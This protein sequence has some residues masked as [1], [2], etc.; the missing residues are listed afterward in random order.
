[1]KR[2]ILIA[3]S[4]LLI[5]MQTWAFHESK[6]E[7]SGFFDF[8]YAV[9]DDS[10]ELNGFKRGQFELD[11]AG[12]LSPQVS[13]E[14]A[15]ALGESN[16]ELGAGLLDIHPQEN[17]GVQIGQFDVPVGRDFNYYPSPERDLVSTPLL[18]EKTYDSWND[19]G[20]QGYMSMGDL[21]IVLY[22]VNGA[23]PTNNKQAYGGKIRTKIANAD[24]GISYALDDTIR[25]KY[26]GLDMTCEIG[27]IEVIGEVLQLINGENN[28]ASAYY[29]QTK[30]SL[31]D[32]FIVG[33]YGS[34]A[35]ENDWD[36]DSFD[37]LSRLSLGGG[38]TLNEYTSLKVEY[39][40]NSEWGSGNDTDNDGL[41]LQAVA[42]F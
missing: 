6:I 41:V 16:F 31:N 3:I 15:L 17:M 4:A 37:R 25:S 5:T 9:H 34:Y 36:G 33:R 22:L 39:Q 14:G 42:A 10:G 38:Y 29:L 2:I 7:W 13:F 40:I 27:N 23:A 21:S 8:Q 28:H 32:A 24:F 30:L 11:I 19:L 35:D 1:M 20:L 18:N 12:D 26:L